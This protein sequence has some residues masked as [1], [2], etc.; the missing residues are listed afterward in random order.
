VA[1]KKTSVWLRLATV[2]LDFLKCISCSV[3]PQIVVYIP[4]LME[5]H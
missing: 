1:P 3:F 4:G 5:H 2:F